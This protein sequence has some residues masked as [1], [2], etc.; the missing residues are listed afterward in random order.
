VKLD[1]VDRHKALMPHAE[2]DIMPTAGHAS[3]LGRRRSLQPP[4][5]DVSI[6]SL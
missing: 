6:D 4:P 5:S 1:A 2:V 3:L